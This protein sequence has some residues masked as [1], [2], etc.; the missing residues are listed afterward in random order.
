MKCFLLMITVL[1]LFQAPLFAE[2]HWNYIIASPWFNEWTLSRGTARIK[3]DGK[4]IYITMIDSQT[5]E[6][7]SIEGN[8]K[9]YGPTTGEFYSIS[10]AEIKPMICIGNPYFQGAKSGYC[11]QAMMG[12]ELPCTETITLTNPYGFFIGLTRKQ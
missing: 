9:G 6:Q 5:S 3:V 8:T 11:G 12:Q 10:N 4:K 1:F 2:E 7:M